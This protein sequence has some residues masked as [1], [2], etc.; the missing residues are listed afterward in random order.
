M[1]QHY[2]RRG[3]TRLG[4]W[5]AHPLAFLLV[6]GFGVAWYLSE[7]EKFDFAAG[8]ALATWFMT[9]LI[10]RSEQRDEQAIPRSACGK[11]GVM[12]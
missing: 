6:I 9:L 5:S 11:F 1:S 12:R 2:I 7:S 10:Q 8:A 4:D 3:L